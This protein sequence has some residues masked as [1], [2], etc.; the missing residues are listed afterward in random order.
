MM[1]LQEFSLMYQ[2]FKN[3]H[4][5]NK[6]EIIS[7]LEFYKLSLPN[8]YEDQLVDFVDDILLNINDGLIYR[9]NLYTNILKV[10]PKIVFVDPSFCIGDTWLYRN[11]RSENRPCA[12]RLCSLLYAKAECIVEIDAIKVGN[13]YYCSDGNHRIYVAYLTNRLVKISF[14]EEF[15]HIQQI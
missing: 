5:N 9:S 14:K 12:D 6:N 3:S 7:W 11:D 10:D 15:Q 13:Y 2:A 8:F 1:T 4:Q